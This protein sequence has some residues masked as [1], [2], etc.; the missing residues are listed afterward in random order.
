MNQDLMETR[1]TA[2]FTEKPK[3]HVKMT[4]FSE[5]K[6]MCGLITTAGSADGGVEEE[7]THC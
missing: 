4:D 1:V 3:S 5:S 7:C 6:Q 2:A